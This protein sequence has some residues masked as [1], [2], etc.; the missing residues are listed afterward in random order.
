MKKLSF[1]LVVIFLI[2]CSP[3]PEEVNI[4]DSFGG[5]KHTHTARGTSSLAVAYCNDGSVHWQE[6]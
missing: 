3:T 4:C 2:G 5:L 1:L 6:F